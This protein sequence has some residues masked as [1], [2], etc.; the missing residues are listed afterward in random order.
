MKT[1]HYVSIVAMMGALFV[2]AF[3]GNP[4]ETNKKRS[5]LMKER[6]E[7]FKANIKP[8]VDAER[9]KLEATLSEA[10]KKE[11]SR[12]REEII[13]QKLMENQFFFE[14]RESRI[15]GEPFN[16]GLWLEIE[17]QKIMIENLHDQAKLI[18]NKY[19]PQID[20]M[21]TDLRASLRDV[22]ETN[23][24]Y[25]GQMDGQRS[26]KDNRGYGQGGRS[27]GEGDGGRFG[28]RGPGELG[29]GFHGGFGPGINRGLDMVSFLLWDVNRG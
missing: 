13:K 10:D 29:Y 19:R 16:E 28:H 18:A 4:D 24:P 23:R 5:E 8:K 22:S 26:Q 14:A 27:F 15:K 2:T 1:K 21:V 17:A 11:I 12:I 9:N 25:R 6:Y 7:Y 3:A 20:D